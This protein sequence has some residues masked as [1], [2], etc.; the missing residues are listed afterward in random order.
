MQKYQIMSGYGV[1]II[2]THTHNFLVL[3]L[4]KNIP[5]IQLVNGIFKYENIG[6]RIRIEIFE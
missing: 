1:S 4:T 5:N 6:T 2:H 3:R